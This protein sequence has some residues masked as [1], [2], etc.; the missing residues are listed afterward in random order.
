[1][2]DASPPF[3]ALSATGSSS[4]TERP[5]A[6]AIL[7]ITNSENRYNVEKRAEF[8]SVE[9]NSETFSSEEEQ[10]SWREGSAIES[11]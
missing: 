6:A 9:E 3:T 7:R 2:L 4:S 10:K 8:L 1:M 11:T 5:P